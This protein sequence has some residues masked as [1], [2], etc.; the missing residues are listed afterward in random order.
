MLRGRRFPRPIQV[1]CRWMKTRR[2]TSTVGTGRCLHRRKIKSQ[3][4]LLAMTCL[5]FGNQPQGGG[6]E[7]NSV[8]RKSTHRTG[9]I[10]AVDAFGGE[11]VQSQ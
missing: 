10:F 5:E 7:S 9:N 2:S 1:L 4:R 3:P 8:V 11:S 6:T